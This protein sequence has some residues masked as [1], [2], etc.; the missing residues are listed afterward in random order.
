MFPPKETN[1]TRPADSKRR[2]FFLSGRSVAE[3]LSSHERPDPLLCRM[4]RFD[5]ILRGCESV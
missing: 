3:C 4:L 1:R 2:G 5:C